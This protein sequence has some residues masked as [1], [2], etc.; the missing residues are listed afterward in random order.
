M[1]SR[2]KH[3]PLLGVRATSDAGATSRVRI[4]KP[5]RCS[6][7]ICITHGAPKAWKGTAQGQDLW[8][9][10]AHPSKLCIVPWTSYGLHAMNMPPKQFSQPDWFLFA[11]KKLLRVP[12]FLPCHLFT[13]TPFKPMQQIPKSVHTVHRKSHE[14]KRKLSPTEVGIARLWH[15]RHLDMA[16]PG[17]PALLLQNHPHIEEHMWHLGVGKGQGRC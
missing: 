8:E 4:G 6:K 9:I 16:L 17:L 7:H 5:A 1:S 12:K 11:S 13:M 10:R 3:Y 15:P 14:D 2:S